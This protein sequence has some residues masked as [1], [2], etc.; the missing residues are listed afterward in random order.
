MTVD[1]AIYKLLSGAS[2]VTAI[3]TSPTTQI[4]ARPIETLP[5]ITYFRISSPGEEDIPN[6][7]ERW[8]FFVRGEDFS[9][10]ANISDLIYNIL[11]NGSGTVTDGADSMIIDQ[12]KCLD[13]GRSPEARGEWFEA[14]TDFRITWRNE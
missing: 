8:R 2:A 7:W 12:T 10:V 11:E 5:Q 4:S 1:H 14:F 6:R 3:L 13:H 9:T